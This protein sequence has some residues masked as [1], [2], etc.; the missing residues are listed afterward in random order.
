MINVDSPAVTKLTPKHVYVSRKITAG[1]DT[2]TRINN[3]HVILASPCQADYNSTNLH[4]EESIS[5]VL[6]M[7]FS[8]EDGCKGGTISQQSLCVCV[9]V[10][11]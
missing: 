9:C 8:S 2:E 3:I 4:L 7:N 6:H 1:A 10:C 5:F 11:V